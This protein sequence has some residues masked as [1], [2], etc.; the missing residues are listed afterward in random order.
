MALRNLPSKDDMRLADDLQQEI[1]YEIDA[2]PR[3]PIYV[4]APGIVK[5][6]GRDAKKRL[7]AIA[8]DMFIAFKEEFHGGVVLW[9]G[10]SKINE[11]TPV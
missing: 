5:M 9:L 1:D 11:L 3:L 2:S 7:T 10:E 6:L 8:L 4:R